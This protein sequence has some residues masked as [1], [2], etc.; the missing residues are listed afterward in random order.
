M[1]MI[2]FHGNCFDITKQNKNT[3]YK[4][5]RGKMKGRRGKVMRGEEREWS[6]KGGRRHPKRTATRD[7]SLEFSQK[8]TIRLYP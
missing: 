1:M 4:E 6:R 2:K 7:F 8:A 5:S 3:K